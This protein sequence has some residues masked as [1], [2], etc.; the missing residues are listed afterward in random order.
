[1]VLAICIPPSVF[2]SRHGARPV[3]TKY[4]F[5]WQCTTKPFLCTVDTRRAACRQQISTIYEEHTIGNQSW[6]WQFAFLP[7]SFPPDTG[8]APSLRNTFFGW[9][10]TAKPF[11]VNRRD[12][13]CRV[14]KAK[15][16]RQWG[17]YNLS[18]IWPLHNSWFLL[19]SLPSDTGHAPSL[20]K[21]K[22]TAVIQKY[23]FLEA[24]RRKP[25]CEPC[26]LQIS[27]S[28]GKI[29][30]FSKWAFE[31][32]L[33]SSGVSPF[34]HG[35]CRVSPANINKQRGNTTFQQMGL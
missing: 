6:F 7:V 12:A 4:I 20:Q 34:R 5:G 31:Q 24:T 1:M 23:N 8:H 16:N 18:G 13:A 32:F 22:R 19:V 33:I 17:K 11:C 15:I 10:R 21:Y 30:P 14:S 35:A 3:S 27:T 29:Q 26:R 9:Q 28:K 25:F 2:P